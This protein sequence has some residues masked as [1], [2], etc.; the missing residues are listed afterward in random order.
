MYVQA[1]LLNNQNII[2]ALQ[3]TGP[4]STLLDVGCWDGVNT[5]V[6]ITA[7][8]AEKSLGIEPVSSA[9]AKSKKRGIKTFVV[10]ADSGKWPLKDGSVDCIVSNQVVE[11]LSDL[12]SFFAQAQRVLKPGG[13]IITSTN[14]LS[15]LHNIFALL[16]GW[17]PFDLTNSSS[18]KWG[19]GNPL[20]TH[21]GEND[22]RGLTWTHK[23]IYTAHWL[24]EWQ[25]VYGFIPL[26]IYGAGLYP[27]PAV[28][29]RYVAKYSA[30]I[31]TLCQKRK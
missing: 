11:H 24:M 2:K 31:T 4:H 15:S 21:R 25:Q 13:H 3:K 28:F 27:L 18:F 23:T 26:E 5:Q 7:A 12:D 29:G 16:M 9:A 8:H 22:K 1:E 6:W 10:K 17:A 19:I 30:F 14:N 20:A